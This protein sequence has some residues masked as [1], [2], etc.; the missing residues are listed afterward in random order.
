LRTEM[1]LLAQSVWSREI[2]PSVSSGYRSTDL[3]QT[4]IYSA[5]A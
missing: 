3:W 4:Y 2:R 1:S 5:S